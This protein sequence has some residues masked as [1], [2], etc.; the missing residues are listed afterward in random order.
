LWQSCSNA[1]VN[2]MR[3]ARWGQEA[4]GRRHVATSLLKHAL[5]SRVTSYPRVF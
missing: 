2:N 4:T 1:V 5:S 3:Q